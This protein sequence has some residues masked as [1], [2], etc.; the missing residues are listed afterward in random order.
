MIDRLTVK[1]GSKIHGLAISCG[2]FVIFLSQ[3]FHHARRKPVRVGLILQQMEF[4]GNQ[5]LNIIMI[6]A[7]FTGAVFGLQIGGIFVVFKAEG[8]MGGAT[9]IAL[10]TELAPLVTAF[11]L[12][13]RVGSAMTSEI[14]TMVVN[15][16]VDAMEAM[17]VDPIHYLVVPRVIASLIIMPLLCG[18]FMFLGIVGA[19]IVGSFI[20]RVDEG[21]FLDKLIHLTG[22]DDIVTG[23]RKMFFFAAIIS[24]ISCR[25]GLNA[26]KGAK[27]VGLATTDAVVKALLGVL[28]MDFFISFFQ[29][30]WM[31]G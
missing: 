12:T 13:G 9:A 16:Q 18:I 11:L 4:I 21:L 24:S 10:T 15:E 20:F 26:A 14:A 22:A 25:Y 1:L 7:I 17:G 2:A 19:Y 8:M 23:L 27:G 29:I 30:R 6:T 5:S 3:I 28:C 31:S